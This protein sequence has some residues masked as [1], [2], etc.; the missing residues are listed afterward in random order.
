LFFELEPMA[1]GTRRAVFTGAGVL[2]P[3]GH[4]LASFWDGLVAGRSGVRRVTAYNP[5][6]LPCHFFAELEPAFDAKKFIPATNKDGRKSL[7]KMAKTVQMGLC[8][9]QLCMDNAGLKKGD[10]SPFRFGIEFGCVMVATDI[11]DLAKAAKV[12]VEGDQV[13]MEKWGRDGLPEI[14]PIWMLKFLPNMPACHV[15][16]FF[17]AQGPNNTVTTEDAAGLLALGEAYRLLVRDSADFFLVGGCESKINPVSFS[18]Y[19]TFTKMSKVQDATAVRPFDATRDGTIL[20]EA[21]TTLGL[22]ELEHAKN[23]N[24]TILGE[25]AGFAAGFDKGLS[26]DVL[27]H[28]IRKALKEAAI[29]VDDVDHVNAHAAGFPHEDAFEARGIAAVFGTKTPVVS[30][31]GHLG[32]SGAASNTTELLASLLAFRHGTLPGTIN[33]TKPAEGITVHTATRPITKPYAVKISHT[34]LGQC[35]V[36]VVKKWEGS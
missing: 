31:K 21:A 20:G 25:L 6:K 17:D 8:A 23:R 29:T 22:E 36:A 1:A 35:A 2:S 28:V 4:D 27:A 10:I 24:A 7:S 12:S 16:I 34:D 14:I 11:N 9:S 13:N 30:Y 32:H 33:V 19:N 5:E 15:S 26:G 3:L 18:R